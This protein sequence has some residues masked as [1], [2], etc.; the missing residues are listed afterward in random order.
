M[1]DKGTA[2]KHRLQAV[3]ESYAEWLGSFEWD[4]FCTFTTPYNLTLK[5][6]RRLM[7]KF[8]TDLK[9]GGSSPFFWVA[10]PFD[11][12]EGYHTHALLKVPECYQFIHLVQLWQ[13][14]SGCRNMKRENEKGEKVKVHARVE[15]RKYNPKLGARHYVGKYMMKS[16]ADYDF[17][18]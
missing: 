11:V 9:A 6:A 7:E 2:K 16:G 10:E 3:N 18:K 14:A 13:V 8:H 12:K 5:S 1:K 17:L 4:Y 15:Y